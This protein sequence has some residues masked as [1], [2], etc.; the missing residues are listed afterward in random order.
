MRPSQGRRGHTQPLMAAPL[1]PKIQDLVARLNRDPDSKI[2]LQ[3]AEEYRK[4]GL[5]E[6]ALLVCKGG[7]K[8]HPGY[9][10]ARVALGRIY[11]ALNRLEEARAEFEAVVRTSPE[12][13]LANRML[14]DVL[15]LGGDAAGARERYRAV[16]QYGPADNEIRHKLEALERGEDPRQVG[17]WGN[18]PAASSSASRPGAFEAPRPASAP[19]PPPA[20][21]ASGTSPRSSGSARPSASGPAAASPPSSPGERAALRRGVPGA[22]AGAAPAPEPP[23]RPPAPVAAASAPLPGAALRRPTAPPAGAASAAERAAPG[24]GPAPVAARPAPEAAPSARAPRDSVSTQTLAE[25]YVRQGFI[26]RAIEVYRRMLSHDPSNAEIGRR[27][28]ELLHLAPEEPPVSAG[29]PARAR[30][31][32]RAAWAAEPGTGPQA[33][34]ERSEAIDRLE[35]WLRAIRGGRR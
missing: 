27:L 21:V 30:E 32:D 6:E 33:P 7:L 1:N 31:P 14:G 29:A 12:N 34:G 20:A 2:F 23:P 18:E 3:L 28:S 17:R 9:H 24:P 35:R 15:A 16:V 22:P 26:D 5:L 10:S 13:L 19:A 25:L 4:A 11:L 8:K